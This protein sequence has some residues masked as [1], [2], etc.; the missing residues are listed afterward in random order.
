MGKKSQEH[1]YI[2]ALNGEV[3]RT[4]HDKL[5]NVSG[6]KSIYA[7]RIYEMLMRW[8]DRKHVTITVDELKERMLLTSKAYSLFG[9]IKQKVI[10]PAMDE[11]A[12]YSDINPSYELIKKCNKVVSVKFYF[13]YKEGRTPKDAL[14]EDALTTLKVIK[15]TLT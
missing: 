3:L 14:R 8:K 2:P 13:E 5:L 12:L 15:E 9:C 6:M 11:I 4:K 1:P 7:I 10:T